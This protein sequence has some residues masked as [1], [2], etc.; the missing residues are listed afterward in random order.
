MRNTPASKLLAQI[1]IGDKAVDRAIEVLEVYLK[2]QPADGQAMTLLGAALMSK[3]QNVRA[4]A[5]MQQALLTKDLPQFRTVLGLSLMRSGQRVPARNA[6]VLARPN[7]S[8]A[9]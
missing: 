7:S 4:T 9:R 8:A 1:Y 5:L 3:G 2:A 6:N